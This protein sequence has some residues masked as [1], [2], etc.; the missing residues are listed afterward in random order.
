MKKNLCNSDAVD[1]ELFVRI[2][3]LKMLG[4]NYGFEISI[5]LYSG[6]LYDWKRLKQLLK[7]HKGFG[8]YLFVVVGGAT[9]ALT[10]IPGI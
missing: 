4:S 10:D 5:V 6:H 2:Y 1:A 3:R 9:K 7:L 8:Q